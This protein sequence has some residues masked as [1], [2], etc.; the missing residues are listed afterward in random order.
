MLFFFFCFVSLWLAKV[1]SLVNRKLLFSRDSFYKDAWHGI[2]YYFIR[3]ELSYIKELNQSRSWNSTSVDQTKST[4][5]NSRVW[6]NIPGVTWQPCH[7]TSSLSRKPL[8][9]AASSSTVYMLMAVVAML[10]GCW[11]RDFPVTGRNTSV[12][13]VLYTATCPVA[14][15]GIIMVSKT[16]LRKNG[17][18]VEHPGGKSTGGSEHFEVHGYNSLV[19]PREFFSNV[20]IGQCSKPKTRISLPKT[21]RLKNY[22]WK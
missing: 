5:S 11:L 22:L 3:Q 15:T 17:H 16:T 14:P 6:L 9:N 10:A 19:N 21:C 8:G 1:I 13:T 18:T 2:W 12:N 20:S 4:G 7:V